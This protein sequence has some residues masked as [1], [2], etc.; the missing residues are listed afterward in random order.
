MTPTKTFF[1]TSGIGLKDRYGLILG[2]VIIVIVFFVF[3]SLA[4]FKSI[5]SK[6]LLKQSLNASEL[7]SY[8][9]QE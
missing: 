2:S 3:S 9:T 8:L 6:N 1:S 7:L 5:P 4:C